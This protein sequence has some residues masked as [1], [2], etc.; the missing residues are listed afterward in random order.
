MQKGFITLS[1]LAIILLGMTVLGGGGF[2]IYKV[3]QI[4]KENDKH[5]SELEQKFAQVTSTSTATNFD[6]LTDYATT[7]QPTSSPTDTEFTSSIETKQNKTDTTQDVDNQ[8]YNTIPIFHWNNQIKLTEDLLSSVSVVL[9]EF[10]KI[11]KALSGLGETM[12]DA[13]EDTTGLESD[14][15][16]Q[17]YKSI[18]ED[19]SNVEKYK[20]LYLTYQT[21]L[22]VYKSKSAQNLL[23][24]QNSFLTRQEA[25]SVLSQIRTDTYLDQISRGVFGAWDEYANYRI[26][27][28]EGYD[29]LYA[30]ISKQDYSYTPPPPLKLPT[31]NIPKITKTNCTF[32]DNM[33]NCE[34]SH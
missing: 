20:N 6:N 32:I 1:V 26:D 28:D 31:V 27:R 10:S 21:E 24:A 12:F 30:Y 14:Y 16:L 25:E 11:T 18:K 23:S 33:V 15:Y 2:A 22:N 19:I 5:V 34:T 3:I 13:S 17:T 9:T 8:N 7:T 29:E 4:Q